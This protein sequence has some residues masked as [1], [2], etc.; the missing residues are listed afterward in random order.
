MTN[1]PKFLT[2]PNLS[3]SPLGDIS[4]HLETLLL[5]VTR[6]D[7]K[8]RSISSLFT[9]PISAEH[10]RSFSGG[11]PLGRKERLSPHQPLFWFQTDR[12]GVMEWGRVKK[13]K[14]IPGVS[15]N[16]SSVNFFQTSLC[17]RLLARQRRRSRAEVRDP[18]TSS[19]RT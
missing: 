17:S 2:P 14:K 10:A 19:P 15:D 9:L 16:R 3:K 1:R 4:S 8:S 18:T 12:Q 13:T 6:V 5:I 7:P 11:V